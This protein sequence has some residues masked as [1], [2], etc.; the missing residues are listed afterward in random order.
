MWFTID[1][2]EEQGEEESWSVE[3]W[4]LFE[5]QNEIESSVRQNWL[6]WG[7]DLVDRLS[8]SYKEENSEG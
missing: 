2:Y 8:S 7:I 1:A 3:R 5:I 6:D 4:Q